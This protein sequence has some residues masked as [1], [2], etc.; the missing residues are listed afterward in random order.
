MQSDSDVS[1]PRPDPT[2][3]PLSTPQTD[4]LA[5]EEFVKLILEGKIPDRSIHTVSGDIELKGASFGVPISVKGLCFTGDVNFSEARFKRGLDLSGCHFKR[6]LNLS[7]ARVGG[8]F[9][10]V[11]LHLLQ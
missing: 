5:A 3:S 4:T 11:R 8:P 6:T 1:E 9:N 10:V 7:D 2:S